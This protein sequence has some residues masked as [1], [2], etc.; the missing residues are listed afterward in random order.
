MVVPG[1]GGPGRPEADAGRAVSVSPLVRRI[2]AP[3]PSAL[4]G[5]G[6]NTYLVGGRPP[7]TVI[8]PGPADD[9]HLGAVLAAAPEVGVILVTHTHADHSPGAAGLAAATGAPVCGFGPMLRP[10]VEHHD[11]TFRADRLL[12]D[13]DVVEGSD[14]RLVAVHTPGHASNH[15]CFLLDGGSEPRVLF[16]GDHVMQG[17]TVVI[18]P[19]DGDMAEYLAQLERVRA[20]GLDR[21]LPGH[22]DPIDDPD[23]HLQDLLDHRAARAAKVLAALARAGPAGATCQELVEVAYDDVPAALHPVAVFTTWAILRSSPGATSDRPDAVDGTWRAAG[24][25]AASGHS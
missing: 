17:S 2:L 16:A 11:D 8:D 9:R 7:V 18:A 14:H 23:A 25:G 15:L 19:L 24:S 12:V 10:G 21:I 4:T 6:T 5:R 1:F 3:N 22:G 13:G 20:L